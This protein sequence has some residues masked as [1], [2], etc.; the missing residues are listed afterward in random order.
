[1]SKS[2]LH[3]YSFYNLEYMLSQTLSL[4]D[5]VKKKVLRIV[6]EALT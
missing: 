3:I 4:V 1:M 5:T 2:L 6:K